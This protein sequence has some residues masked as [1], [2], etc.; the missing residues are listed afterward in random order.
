MS[1]HQFFHNGQLIYEWDQELD[2]INIYIKPPPGV[3][4][5]H[6][7]CE[8]SPQKLVLGLKGNPPFIDQDFFSRVKHKD[9]FWTIDDEIHITLQKNEQRRNVA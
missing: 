7:Q 1:R 9:S 5:R 2:T 4:A 8:I 6:I 3:T